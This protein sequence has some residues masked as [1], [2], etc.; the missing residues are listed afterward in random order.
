MP[1]A[2]DRDVVGELCLEHR[3]KVFAASD[4]DHGVSVGE[5]GKNADFV[6]VFE[7]SAC[8]HFEIRLRKY[9]GP[10]AFSKDKVKVVERVGRERE[11]LRP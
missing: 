9:E 1:G 10:I 8:G 3:V 5:L 4:S 11:R 7:L 2:E 6:A